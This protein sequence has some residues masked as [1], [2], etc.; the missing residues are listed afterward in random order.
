MNRIAIKEI[1]LD[2]REE[3]KSILAHNNLIPRD[4][5]SESDKILQSGPAKIINGAR[6][7]GKSTFAHQLL[8]GK[9]YGYTNFDDERL[10]GVT[11]K[12]LNNFL[13]VLNEINPNFE[14]LL[15]DEIQNI[16]GWELF[17]NRL[18]RKKYNII[19]TGSNSKLL[20]KEL[21]THLTGRYITV[22]LYPFYFKEYL[23]YKKVNIH[24]DDF[25]ITEKR[26]NLKRHFEEYLKFGGMPE[27]IGHAKRNEYLRE[28]FDK[29]ITR[30]VATRYN[31]KYVR[32]LKEI[33]LYLISNSASKISLNKIKNI[34]EIK[35]IHTIKNH[36]E[37][38]ENSYL[39]FQLNPFSFKLKEQL[40]QQKKIYCID[41]GL[42]T[43]LS[44]S[45]TSD[46]GKLIENLIFV[47]LKRK[48]NEIYYYSCGNYEVDFM[49]QKGREIT[50]LIQ[51]SFS[52][53]DDDTK[54]REIESLLKASDK[55][56]CNNLTIITLDEEGEEKI[57]SKTIKILPAWKF[58][59]QGIPS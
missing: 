14:Y 46:Y 36:I 57:K 47:D 32:D 49:T 29:I 39:I 48:G 3:I 21:A 27:T 19:I 1:L 31:I 9:N 38:L 50:D 6:R 58:L 40:K 25:Y 55:L 17:I 5:M 11:T 13:E 52:I 51:V 24:P 10:I 2:Q 30:D 20:S 7:C 26:A 45:M 28:L 56:R 12:D 16:K 35:K 43:S 33:A 59:F 53:S 22:E 37:Y 23:L 8:A 4:L 18:L 34:F 54:S 41:N 15:F 42:I 44:H